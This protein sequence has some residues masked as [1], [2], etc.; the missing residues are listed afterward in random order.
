MKSPT[1]P[2]NAISPGRMLPPSFARAG[3]IVS[4]SGTVG[5]TYTVQRAATLTG[6]WTAI[7]SVTIG[8][9]SIGSCSDTNPPAVAAFY[10]TVHQ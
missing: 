1:I 6:P 5:V 4:F 9:T 2:A 10:R 8:A 7:A 3:V